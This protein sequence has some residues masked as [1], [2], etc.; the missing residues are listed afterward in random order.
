MYTQINILLLCGLSTVASTVSGPS[1]VGSVVGVASSLGVASSFPPSS[2]V[3]SSFLVSSANG[4]ELPNYNEK[5]K[6]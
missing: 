3:S 2:L 6:I 5:L 1:A 4:S